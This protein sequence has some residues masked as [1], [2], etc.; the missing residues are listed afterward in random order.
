MHPCLHSEHVCN[1]N[2]CL[3]RRRIPFY[4]HAA[5]PSSR[6][7]RYSKTLLEVQPLSI[8][9][10]IGAGHLDHTFVINSSFWAVYS[11]GYNQEDEVEWYLVRLSRSN[12]K[13]RSK[14]FTFIMKP[15]W[16]WSCRRGEYCGLLCRMGRLM[17]FCCWYRGDFRLSSG[18][19]WPAF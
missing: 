14:I 10:R 12:R 4:K 17:R 3:N 15:L 2:N 11:H 8:A 19:R 16:I 18:D 1:F 13:N 9:V 6:E 5:Y 7:V